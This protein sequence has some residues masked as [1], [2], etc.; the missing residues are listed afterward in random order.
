MPPIVKILLQGLTLAVAFLLLWWTL[1]RVEWVEVLGVKKF[2][3]ATEKKIGDLFIDVFVPPDDEVHDKKVKSPIDSL[4]GRICRESH[5]DSAGI[6]VHLVRKDEINAF[7]L[8]DRHLVI[9]TGL[10]KF[11]DSPEELCGVVS[12]E[13]AHIEL[14]H[15]M[16]KLA[17][18]VGL[19]VLVSTTGTGSETIKKAAKVLSS[20]AFDRRMEKEADIKAVEFLLNA[21]IHPEPFSEFLSKMA[22]KNPK[23]KNYTW[24]S[25]HPDSDKRAEYILE[26]V[27]ASKKPD[28]YIVPLPPAQ[29]KEIKD[30]F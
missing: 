5:I 9:Y 1:D 28:S 23:M 11:C 6:K 21:R 30:A 3:A 17:K 7:A 26:R 10:I 20:T 19:S 22:D 13:I 24:L 8:P 25:T 2:S 15:V 12:H 4:V 18:E 29:W 16:Q 27:N 14:E